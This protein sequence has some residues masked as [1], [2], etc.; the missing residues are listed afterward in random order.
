MTKEL[1]KDYIKSIQQKDETYS[2]SN[3]FNG[4]YYLT[5]AKLFE[6]EKYNMAW[7]VFDEIEE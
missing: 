7:N 6:P 3:F 1:Q 4:L 2:F 5:L